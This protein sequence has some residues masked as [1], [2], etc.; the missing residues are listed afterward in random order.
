[1]RYLK[2]STIALKTKKCIVCGK[3]CVWF[4]KKRCQSCARIQDTL[5]KMESVTERV[6]QEDDLQDLVADADSIVS[7]YVR[8]KNTDEYGNCQCYT[9][10]TILPYQQMQAGHYIRRGHLL[11]RW[12]TD[13]NIK[14]QCVECNSYKHGNLAVYSQNLENEKPGLPDILMEESAIVYKPTREE[15][16]QIIA[17]YTPKVKA[18]KKKLQ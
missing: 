5:K 10:P 1:M 17:D 4:S 16:R 2:N 3:D 14:P 13:R 12:D 18:L 7:L 15:I 11:L 8:L 9:C 6:I